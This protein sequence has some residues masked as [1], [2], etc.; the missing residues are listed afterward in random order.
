M[1]LGLPHPGDGRFVSLDDM[2]AELW[3]KAQEA[4]ASLGVLDEHQSVQAERLDALLTRLDAQAAAHALLGERVAKLESDTRV[5]AL[6]QRLTALEA[7]V[8]KLEG[9]PAFGVDM[10]GWQT[11]EQVAAAAADPNVEF[12][13]LKATEGM[14]GRNSL[15]PAQRAAAGDKFIGAYHFAWPNQDPAKE[16][17]NFLEYAALKPGQWAFYD[18]EDWGETDPAKPN[19]ARD[20]AMRDATPWTQRLSFQFEWSRIVKAAGIR[21]GAYHNWE[22]IKGL[23][24]AS[25]LAQ[26]PTLTSHPLWLAQWSGVAGKHDTVTSKDGTNPDSWPIIAH[27]Y[28]KTPYD[29]N[30]TPD[31]RALK[32]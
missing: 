5:E 20:K 31:I 22:W 8:R 26:W 12:I 28:A 23:R 11:V 18:G 3:A 25:T 6:T 21:V 10:S 4:L 15:Y 2:V 1:D 32:E 14:G 19:Y 29:L 24:G 27:Q 9:G 17:A 30:W 13:I 16:A 7:R